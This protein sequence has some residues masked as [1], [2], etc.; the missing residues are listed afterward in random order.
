[1]LSVLAVLIAAL[2][3]A[4]VVGLALGLAVATWRVT[5]WADIATWP[6]ELR[7]APPPET[8]LAPIAWPAPAI[9]RRAQR[10]GIVLLHGMFGFDSLGVGAARVVYFREVAPRLE[11]AGYDVCT[12]RVPPIG[13]VPARAEALA[14][15]I[16]DLP[17]DR[18]TVFAHS[19]GGLDARWA[20]ARLGLGAR[21][22][23]L[24]TIGTPH[25]GTPLAD[26]LALRPIRTA[27]SMLA[28]FGLTV[29]ALD[30]L[31]TWHWSEF[32]RQ[33]PD[34]S[35]VRYACVVGATTD[36]ARV[37]PLLRPTHAYLTHAV[38]ASDGV[39]P[40]R[41]QVWGEI[42][43]EV[44]LDHF[45]QVGWSGG[46]DAAAM[47]MNALTHLRAAPVTRALQARDA[48]AMNPVR[49]RSSPPVA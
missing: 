36:R 32:N 35:G 19:M 27:R 11:A 44:E 49:A 9:V 22:A 26:L 41:S 16:G 7:E 40:G 30:W 3:V 14:R 39:V 2:V 29:D 33:L 13:S 23:N 17:H 1:M 21:I 37:H 20:I 47:V 48:A 45:A 42:L 34:V 8:A 43:A 15:A 28:R 10:P 5:G 4:I 24:V 18:V 12:V 25:H 38:G 31:T 6:R 46:H